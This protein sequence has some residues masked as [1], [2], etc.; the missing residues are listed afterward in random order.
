[1]WVFLLLGSE[2]MKSLFLNAMWH[3][4]LVG[5]KYFVLSHACRQPRA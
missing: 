4:N 3:L 5:E 1:M 2:V